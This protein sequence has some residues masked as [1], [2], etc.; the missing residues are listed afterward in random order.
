L[1]GLVTGVVAAFVFRRRADGAALR[2]RRA[3]QGP[4][5]G[6]WFRP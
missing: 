4:Q 6:D 2:G 1:I 3:P 5:E